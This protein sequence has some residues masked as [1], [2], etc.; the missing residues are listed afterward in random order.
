M[1]SSATITF[2]HQSPVGLLE[3]TA[4]DSELQRVRIIPYGHIVAQPDPAQTT[5]NAILRQTCNQLDEYFS[6]QRTCF[7]IPLSPAASPFQRRLRNAL[8]QLPYGATI[9]YGQLARIC[10]NRNAA[11]AIASALAANP[12]HIVIP[13]HRVIRADGALSGYAAGP[14]AKRYLLQLEGKVAK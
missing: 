6:G 2:H 7:T 10:G 13:C 3:L 5:G 4:T 12:L 9:S 14:Q 1:H 8:I 11:R